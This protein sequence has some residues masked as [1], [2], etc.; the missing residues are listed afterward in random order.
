MGT[1][2]HGTC[3]GQIYAHTDCEPGWLAF[4]NGQL[5]FRPMSLEEKDQDI[6]LEKK[7]EDSKKVGTNE[8]A[9]K[10]S[11]PKDNP[12]QE[13]GEK[14]EEQSEKKEE[15]SEKKEEHSEKKEKL[16]K[17][18]EQ[19]EKK[20]EQP[21]KKEEQPEKKEEQSEKK[22][23][24]PEKKEEQSEKKEEHSEK[25]EEHSEKKEEQ[26][27]KKEEQSE[28]K[29]EQSE[30]KEEQSE[31]KEEQSEKK[32]EQPEK[33]EEQPEKKEEQPEKKEEQPEKKEEQS[34]KKEQQP[35]KKEE[36]SEKKEE[37]QEKKEEQ[38]EKKEGQQEQNE[39]Q[40]ENIEEI[41]LVKSE[42]DI[43]DLKDDQEFDLYEKN[44]DILILQDFPPG[45]VRK[46]GEEQL[47]HLKGRRDK[48]QF[49]AAKIEAQMQEDESEPAPND[50]WS[51]AQKTET[52][53]QENVDGEDALL[54][55]SPSP[56]EPSLLCQVLD[57]KTLKPVCSVFHPV[58]SSSHRRETTS[59]LA[60][61]GIRLYRVYQIP[62]ARRS[63]KKSA[64]EFEARVETFEL[65]VSSVRLASEIVLI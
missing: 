45:L 1:G 18:E 55:Q 56:A 28:K 19:P 53:S 38:S 57:T 34:E 41:V 58:V 65:E 60:G 12:D 61:D 32:G 52:D 63:D 64:E 9:K 10:D 54:D 33:K 7:I 2:L 48:I 44:E 11:Q 5:L 50:T 62:G 4:V 8:N 6:E 42:D 51:V 29:E 20:E 59:H 49:L 46:M 22:E 36:Q 23:E 39:G 16:E 47:E 26:S 13:Q 37:Q 14:K 30:K 35:E 27:E 21:E 15:Q 24:Q 3:R 31:K 25:K 17:K 43:Y 40:P